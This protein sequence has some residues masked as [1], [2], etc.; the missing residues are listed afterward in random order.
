MARAI[1][2]REK[3]GSRLSGNHQQASTT[4]T[5]RKSGRSEETARGNKLLRGGWR[6][7]EITAATLG[8]S[9]TADPVER[10][11]TP[12]PTIAEVDWEALEDRHPPEKC[13]CPL[14][15]LLDTYLHWFVACISGIRHQAHLQVIVMMGLEVWTLMYHQTNLV[16]QYV[17][18]YGYLQIHQKASVYLITPPHPHPPN[19]STN[20]YQTTSI[21]LIIS[22]FFKPPY[23][24][25]G[26]QPS[27]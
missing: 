25:G 8:S 27:P 23:F 17:P 11:I 15:G 21:Y 16:T 12:F 26:S 5:T 6:Y 3:P 7:G 9:G 4:S 18:L 2:E 20:A 1:G 22:A 19:A 13:H 10:P 24:L 14:S